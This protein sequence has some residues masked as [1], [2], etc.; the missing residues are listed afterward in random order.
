MISI[1]RIC[2]FLLLISALVILVNGQDCGCK[3][4]EC[5]SKDGFCGRTEEYCG[6][7]C[8]SGNCLSVNFLSKRDGTCSTDSPCPNNLC[9]SRFGYCGTTVDYCGT[10]CQAGACFGAATTAPT[11]KPTTAPTTA[12][13]VA[14]TTRPTAAATSAPTKAA[15]P[16]PTS[17]ATVA[18]T[19][20]PSKAPASSN[21]NGGCSS[22][23]PCPN[24]LCCSKYGYCGNSD[25]YCGNGCQGGPCF[26]ASTTAPTTKPT[27]APSTAPTTRPTTAPTVAPTVAP[28]TKPTVA[29]PTA[30]TT[31]PTSAPTVAP[32]IKPTV[33]PTV[34]PTVAPTSPPSSTWPNGPLKA[35]YV[36]IGL[37]WANPSSTFKAVVDA[38]YNYVVLAFL[39]SNTVWDAATAWASMSAA[40]QQ[41]TI[42]YAHARNARIVVAA[43]GAT[44]FPFS[45][46]TGNAYGSWAANWA[47]AHYLDGVDFDL[48]NFG[49]GFT[50]GTMNTAATIKW[51]ADATNAARAILGD[52]KIISHAPQP[53]YFG[54]VYSFSNAYTEIYKQAPSINFLMVQY[55]NNGPATT[56]EEIFTKGDGKT[57][58]KELADLGIPLNK[59]VVG[60]PIKEDDAGSM[61][62]SAATFNSYVTR[63]KAELGWS[64]GVM[65]WQWHDSDTNSKWIKTIFP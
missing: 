60:K 63:A 62:I 39:V 13:T 58:V 15:T 44:D 46:M 14:P 52:D 10:G 33:A 49:G 25:A 41:A 48:E 6:Q 50:F 29:P 3:P 59:I 5:C 31:R 54:N 51:V 30:P 11:T 23:S 36:D 37:N 22:D 17:P 2:S 56:Y 16:A 28:T 45:I 42:A 26:G 35:V 64:G 40:D 27:T 21:N 4:G 18:P 12:P 32:T 20:A 38:G 34:K 65:G 53:P 57:S 47:N 19:V 61:W 43:G 24:N 1:T 7:G 55:Y 8:K 9:C